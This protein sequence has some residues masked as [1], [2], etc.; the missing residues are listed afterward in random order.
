MVKVL[1]CESGYMGSIPINQP[2]WISGPI[3]LNKVVGLIAND[4]WRIGEI[5]GLI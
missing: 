5:Q 4:C 1:D 3:T 2:F